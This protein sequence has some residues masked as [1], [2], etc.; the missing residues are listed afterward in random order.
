MNGYLTNLQ[1]I[2]IK[3]RRK[4]TVN[5]TESNT[6]LE[7]RIAETSIRPVDRALPSP[8]TKTHEQ[9]ETKERG[10]SWR[11]SRDFRKHARW[12]RVERRIVLDGGS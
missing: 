2:E 1:S 4:K 10:G 11:A 5:K 3:I 7:T 8:L 12:K 9:G 6:F